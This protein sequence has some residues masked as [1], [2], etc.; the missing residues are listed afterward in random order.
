VFVCGF[1]SDIMAAPR[2]GSP[3]TLAPPLA[4]R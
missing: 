4:R 3:S 1:H 2:A